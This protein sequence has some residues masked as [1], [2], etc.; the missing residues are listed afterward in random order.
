MGNPLGDLLGGIGKAGLATG[1]IAGRGTVEASEFLFR[2]PGT[3]PRVE[4]LKPEEEPELFVRFF[5]IPTPFMQLGSYLGVEGWKGFALDMIT[6]PLTYLGGWGALTRGGQAGKIARAAGGAERAGEAIQASRVARATEAYGVA[7]KEAEVLETGARG[8][9]MQAGLEARAGVPQIAGF[10]PTTAERIGIVGEQARIAKLTEASKAGDVAREIAS[11]GLSPERATS[12]MERLVKTS[13]QLDIAGHQSL[14]DVLS[15]ADNEDEALA[16]IGKLDDLRKPTAVTKGAAGEAAKLTSKAEQTT[17]FSFKGFPIAAN[18]PGANPLIRH[19]VGRGEML[20]VRNA[21][22]RDGLAAGREVLQ[23]MIDKRKDLQNLAKAFFE[24]GDVNQAMGIAK[25]IQKLEPNRAFEVIFGKNQRPFW[26]SYFTETAKGSITPLGRTV[27]AQ[28]A[29]GQRALLTIGLPFGE[30]LGIAPRTI[31]VG[32][33]IINSVAAAAEKSRFL[34]SFGRR[35]AFAGAGT[36][37][38]AKAGAFD[39]APAFDSVTHLG[40]VVARGVAGLAGEGP[41]EAVDSIFKQYYGQVEY[42]RGAAAALGN[43]MRY[44]MGDKADLLREVADQPSLAFTGFSSPDFAIAASTITGKPTKFLMQNLKPEYVGKITERDITLLQ[45]ME[46]MHARTNKLLEERGLL[47]EAIADYIPRLVKA[48]PGKEEKVEKWLRAISNAPTAKVARSHFKK[49]TIPTLQEAFAMEKAGLLEVEHDPGKLYQHWGEAVIRAS[50]K[51]TLG[52]RLRAATVDGLPLATI[53]GSDIAKANPKAYAKVLDPSVVRT[54]SPGPTGPR[55]VLVQEKHAKDI[56][57]VLGGEPLAA[58]AATPFAVKLADHLLRLNSALKR[59]VLGFDAVN[60]GVFTERAAGTLGRDYLASPVAKTRMGAWH[61]ARATDMWELATQANLKVGGVL[62]NDIDT[63]LSGLKMAADYTEAKVPVVG[64]MIGKALRGYRQFALRVD[65]PVWDYYH[66]SL[67]MTAFS[68][69]Y[70]RAL[71]DPRFIGRSGDEIAQGVAAHVNNAFSG[72]NWERM[73]LGPAGQ[74]WLRLLMIAPDWT[75]STIKM[76]ADLF[77]NQVARAPFL[78]RDMVAPEVRAAFAR[79]YAI[80][81]GIAGGAMLEL[82][83][84]ATTSDPIHFAKTGQL[85]GHFMHENE[86]GKKLQ[87]ALPAT[88]DGKRLYWVP[89]KQWQD[90]ASMVNVFD[91]NQG[92]LN[93]FKNRAGFVP[94]L[95]NTVVMGRDSFGYPI[96]STKDGVAKGLAKRLGYTAAAFGLPAPAQT[97][98]GVGAAGPRPLRGALEFGLNIRTGRQVEEP[99]AAPPPDERVPPPDPIPVEFVQAL[100][101]EK[102]TNPEWLRAFDQLPRERVPQLQTRFRL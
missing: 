72:Q 52:E 99:P 23:E 68:E 82:A 85:N 70:D 2:H 87:L 21:I 51:K 12:A 30:H 28:T 8:L 10:A 43:E 100:E 20:G 90:F 102:A 47:E 40:D 89:H 50:A 44:V 55:A 13:S 14:L 66:P 97:A 46:A 3:I 18:Y 75:M 67:K 56:V 80:R 53:E 17:V 91:V 69:L 84:L 65:K 4:R 54:F 92:P 71:R 36:A 22:A 98:L 76:G 15:L 78:G 62:E 61:V 48:R 32:A 7:A 16:I 74:R 39:H 57:A 96:V 26:K 83:N 94:T 101:E 25:Q 45:T 1:E 64:G 42:A 35:A 73:W 33:P 63:F 9:Q 38:A 86:E 95:Y 60:Y 24:A 81:A 77:A 93:F 5:G 88:E 37:A 27:A 29:A 79:D 6:D 31:A 49:R 19:M 58:A 41:P 59:A 11:K 34:R